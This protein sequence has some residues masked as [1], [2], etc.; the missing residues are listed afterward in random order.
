MGPLGTIIISS[1]VRGPQGPPGPASPSGGSNA[2]ALQGVALDSSVASPADGALLVYSAN[3]GKW[4]A[5]ST[6]DGGT[7]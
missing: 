1:P 4:V 2:T 6:M 7:F 5:A 3:T